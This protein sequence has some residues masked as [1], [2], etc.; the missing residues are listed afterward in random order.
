MRVREF[1]DIFYKRQAKKLD[2]EIVKAGF[3]L[4][5]GSQIGGHDPH[6]PVCW[7]QLNISIN[8]YMMNIDR[9]IEMGII[10]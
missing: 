6:H 8:N 2:D 10:A 3:S 4:E 5:I 9:R 1:E 7:Q